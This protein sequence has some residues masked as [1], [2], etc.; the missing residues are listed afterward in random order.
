MKNILIFDPGLSDQ[1]GH[2]FTSV[3]R[4][5]DE[6]MAH[7]HEGLIIG[8]KSAD[9]LSMK[10]PIQNTL[11]FSLYLRKAWDKATFLKRAIRMA[12]EFPDLRQFDAVFLPTGDQ[13]QAMA[14]AL[15]LQKTPNTKLKVITWLLFSPRYLHAPNQSASQAAECRYA[16]TDLVQQV[17]PHNISVF[18]E[19]KTL[20]DFYEEILPVSVQQ[21]P[22][23]SVV[24]KKRLTDGAT[25]VMV[26]GC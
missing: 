19:T 22:S 7:Q 23:P 15:A 21:Q 5:S 14:L 10:L 16:F 6:V 11:P 24:G 2:H 20:M 26:V 12:L 4:I 13:I 3:T 9:R 1:A 8:S 17:N 18:C 25:K